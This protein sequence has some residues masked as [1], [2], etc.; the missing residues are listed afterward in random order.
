MLS[1]EV[2]NLALSRYRIGCVPISQ[3]APQPTLPQFNSPG[4][5]YQTNQVQTQAGQPGNQSILQKYYSPLGWISNPLPS[6][7][8]KTDK[9][10]N[11]RVQ[12]ISP[13][14]IYWCV[15]RA[16]TEPK[17]IYLCPIDVEDQMDDKTL[18]ERL[19]LEYQRV[20]TWKGRLLSWKRCLGV[21]FI[22]VCLGSS[23]NFTPLRA[24]V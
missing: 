3:L 20:R 1:V 13:E 21:E 8:N 10:S 23:S 17:R 2:P 15:D 22:K 6:T 4:S 11:N 19:N 18:C 12:G 14:E 7:T 9:V 24:I 16:W 5:S